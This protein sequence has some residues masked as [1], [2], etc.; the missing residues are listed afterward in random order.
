MSSCS[1]SIIS[2]VTRLLNKQAVFS[3]SDREQMQHDG[4]LTEIKVRASLRAKGC[5]VKSENLSICN[6]LCVV[7]LSKKKLL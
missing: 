4:R 6:K 5:D 2:P 1:L 3:F 7:F